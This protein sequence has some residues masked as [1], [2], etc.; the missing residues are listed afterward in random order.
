MERDKGRSHKDGGSECFEG[1]DGVG[2][3]GVHGEEVTGRE[4][5][6]WAVKE[7]SE[8]S[9]FLVKDGRGRRYELGRVGESGD[10]MKVVHINRDLWRGA[11]GGN[12]LGTG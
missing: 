9:P 6:S 5:L 12:G 10:G 4:E 3:P 8:E 7:T 1:C 11:R 2:A